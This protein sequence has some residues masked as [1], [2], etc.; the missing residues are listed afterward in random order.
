MNNLFKTS[1]IWEYFGLFVGEHTWRSTFIYVGLEFIWSS[2]SLPEIRKTLFTLPAIVLKI[3]SPTEI[4][5]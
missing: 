3:I 2:K 1:I 5:H 4:V